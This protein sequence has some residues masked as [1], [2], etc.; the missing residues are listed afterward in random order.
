MHVRARTHHA[1]TTY[2]IC[3]RERETTKMTGTNCT[4]QDQIYSNTLSNTKSLYIHLKYS[5]VY[6]TYN[7]FQM[8]HPFQVQL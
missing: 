7:V 8:E 6:I 1:A 2:S 4:I 5:S 3:A